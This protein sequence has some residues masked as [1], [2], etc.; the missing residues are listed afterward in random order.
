MPLEGPSQ[1]ESMMDF[2]QLSD[3]E[4]M[5]LYQQDQM[6]AF[7]VLY[8]RHSAKV[9]G[10]LRK[11]I[12]NAAEAGDVFQAV[13]MK[14]HRS[15]SLYNSNFP[16]LPWLFTVTK[17]VM[18]DGAKKSMWNGKVVLA[19]ETI[20]SAASEHTLSPHADAYHIDGLERLPEHQRQAI[21]LRYRDDWSFEEIARTLNTTPANARQLISRGIRQLRKIAGVRED[22]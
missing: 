3:E 6:E 17:T 12:R 8:A 20:E 11:R 21:E 7:N 2:T 5:V 14:V 15:R 9:Y 13:F 4:L 16:F 22:Q 19:G 1:R 10:Y 18:I